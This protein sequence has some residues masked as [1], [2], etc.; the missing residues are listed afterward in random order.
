MEVATKCKY[1]IDV[2]KVWKWQLNI[3]RAIVRC[4]KSMK[5]HLVGVE[6]VWKWLQDLSMEEYLLLV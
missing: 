5:E 4:K 1:R 3:N 2:G 6:K